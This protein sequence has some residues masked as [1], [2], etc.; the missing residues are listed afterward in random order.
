MNNIAKER[1]ALGLTQEQLRNIHRLRWSMVRSLSAM[2]LF[3]MAVLPMPKLVI[4]SSR[5]TSLQAQLAGALIKMETLN[6]MGN[7]MPTAGTSLLTG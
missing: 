2:R 4:L 6:C 7:S 3:R 5:I 1:Q